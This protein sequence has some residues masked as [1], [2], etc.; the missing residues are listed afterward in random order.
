MKWW[1]E[2]RLLFSLLFTNGFK[3]HRGSII[4]RVEITISD[5]WSSSNSIS[6]PQSVEN[7]HWNSFFLNTFLLW[8]SIPVSASYYWYHDFRHNLFIICPY[9]LETSTNELLPTDWN[10]TILLTESQLEPVTINNIL[11]QVYNHFKKLPMIWKMLLMIPLKIE[12][13]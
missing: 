6:E 8:F 10:N 5:R 13:L 11:T 7:S 3:Q 4:S 12:E 9:I 1:N 2:Y